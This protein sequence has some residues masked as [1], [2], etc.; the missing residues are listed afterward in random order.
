MKLLLD[1]NISDRL[2]KRLSDL[3]PGSE[4]VV[5]AGFAGMDDAVIWDYAKKHGFHIV[6]QDA[7]FADRIELYGAPPKVIWLRCGN[8]RTS[9]I[10]R[11]LRQNAK[12]LADLESNTDL[13]IIEL[14]S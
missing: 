1:E 12:A 6:T 4:H 11:V 2:L 7:D 13:H 3:Y 10:E 8:T 9:E 5:T 14:F